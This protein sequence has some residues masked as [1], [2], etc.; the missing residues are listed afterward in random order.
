MYQWILVLH[1]V[2]IISWMAGVLYHF[3]VLIYVVER[4]QENAHTR[5]VL[6]TMAQRLYRFIVMPAMGVAYIAGFTLLAKN[7]SLMVGAGWLHAKLLL[8]VV[9]TGWA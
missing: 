6:Q 3:R 1:I 2:A 9:L 5:D 4:G 7:P 8:V